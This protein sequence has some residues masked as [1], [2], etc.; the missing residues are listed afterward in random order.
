MRRSHPVIQDLQQSLG[1]FL[2][3]G[4]ADDQAVAV[5]DL[6][7]DKLEIIVFDHAFAG[8]A[9]FQQADH[10][11]IAT[12]AGLDVKVHQAYELNLGTFLLGSHERLFDHYFGVAQFPS[13]SQS[14]NFHNFLLSAMTIQRTLFFL[15]ISG[16]SLKPYRT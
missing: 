11:G 9:F 15:A 14:K 1:R 10:T 5:E 3:D 12:G 4:G 6:F 2:V 16:R 13:T 8:A 7:V